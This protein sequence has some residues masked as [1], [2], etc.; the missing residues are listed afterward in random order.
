MVTGYTVALGYV[1]GCAEEIEAFVVT[2]CR[3]RRLDPCQQVAILSEIK[4]TGQDVAAEIAGV[5]WVDRHVG[6]WGPCD[7]VE[8]QDRW[9]E[10]RTAPPDWPFAVLSNGTVA[11]W[12]APFDALP[13]H[14]TWLWNDA[15]WLHDDGWQQTAP[16]PT[17]PERPI[18][19]MPCIAV[20]AG[21]WRLYIRAPSF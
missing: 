13:A 12:L 16:R 1:R 21:H 11:V 5:D 6:T 15:D 17:A 2:T 18:A 9:R 19:S 20:I 14:L 10:R 8:A 3:A 7:R 4:S